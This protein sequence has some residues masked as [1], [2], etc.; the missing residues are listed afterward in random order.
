[1]QVFRIYESIKTLNETY[2]CYYKEALDFE[3]QIKLNYE[4]IKLDLSLINFKDDLIIYKGIP[5]YILDEILIENIK[6]QKNK[7]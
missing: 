3:E 1:M 7:I 6:K 4:E 5:I 2:D